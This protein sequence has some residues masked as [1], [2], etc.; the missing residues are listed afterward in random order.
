LRNPHKD[1]KFATVRDSPVELYFKRQI[2][3]ATMYRNMLEIHYNNPD[4]AIEALRNDSLKAFIWDSGRLSYEASRDCD[5]TTAG[6]VFG[7]NDYGI[8]MLKG[9]PW[10][11]ELSQTVLSLHERGFMERLDTHWI[12]KTQTQCDKSESSPA[13]L[14]LANMAGVFI[15]VAAGILLGLLLIFIEIAY[16][17]HRSKKQKRL[18]LARA[19][20]IRWGHVVE[21]RRRKRFACKA[22]SESIDNLPRGGKAR[23]AGQFRMRKQS[24]PV[25]SFSSRQLDE[26]DTDKTKPVS[27]RYCDGRSSSDRDYMAEPRRIFWEEDSTSNGET[28][29]T[30][31]QQQATPKVMITIPKVYRGMFATW[32]Q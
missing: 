1:F 26:P 8:A 7:R 18:E 12:L 29:L 17:K 30:F 5:L 31:R 23:S 21:K 3:Y 13:T 22:T 6:E 15:M 4:E 10:L 32:H 24:Q 16:K 27:M 9:N 11:Y 25:T 14:G 19:A 20:F 28:A 2:E